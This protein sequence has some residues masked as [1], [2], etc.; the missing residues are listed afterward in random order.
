M[1]LR[2]LPIGATVIVGDLGAYKVEYKIDGMVCLKPY[3]TREEQKGN[4]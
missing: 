3:P 2:D 4:E 1:N